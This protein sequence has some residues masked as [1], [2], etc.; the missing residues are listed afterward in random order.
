MTHMKKLAL[1]LALA[2][3]LAAA[4]AAPPPAARAAP[5]ALQPG[6]PGPPDQLDPARLE[7]LQRRMKLALTLG[8]AEALQLDDAAALKLSGQI[9]KFTPRRMATAQQMR[10]SVQVLRRSAKGDKVPAGDVDGAITRL[11]DARAQMQALDREVVTTV[12]RDLPPEKRARAVLFLAKFH[13]RAMQE[14]R[15]GGHGHG[16]PG[17]PGMGPGGPGMGPGPHGPGPGALGM[18]DADDG[19]DDGAGDDAS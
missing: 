16:G 9:E 1:L 15:H 10:D 4:Q 19:W 14:L 13:Q 11:L 12:T 2:P 6:Q 8:L 7:K 3:L 5:P 18:N 17:G